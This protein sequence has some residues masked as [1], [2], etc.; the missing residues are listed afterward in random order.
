MQRIWDLD[1]KQI[2]AFGR[3][4][5]EVADE[6]ARRRLL[7]TGVWYIAAFRRDYDEERVM[8]I[9]KGA[10]KKP[11]LVPSFIKDARREGVE[12][13]IERGREEVA[14]RG[15]WGGAWRRPTWPP[16]RGFP[17]RR[18]MACARRPG[19][20][21]G[22]EGG[23]SGPLRSADASAVPV[24]SSWGALETVR[25][26]ILEAQLIGTEGKPGEASLLG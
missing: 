18:S 23:G 26:S 14:L 24:Q 21:P 6:A 22:P 25:Q 1:D 20:S 13:G 17:K 10:L 8:G 7:L 11:E 3:Q 9:L 4:T 5:E 19:R 16:S 2:A 12:R 15:C